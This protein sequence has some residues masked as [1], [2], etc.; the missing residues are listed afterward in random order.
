MTYFMG[1]K[2]KKLLTED[3]FWDIEAHVPPVSMLKEDV[4]ILGMKSIKRELKDMLNE[5][6]K[7]IALVEGV[8]DEITISK[9][10]FQSLIQAERKLDALIE[11]GVDN[12]SGYGDAMEIYR[13][14]IK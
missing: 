13:E 9:N 6:N 14:L 3:E 5:I 1:L 10:E 11:G 8:E 12:W 7:H 2:I 4:N